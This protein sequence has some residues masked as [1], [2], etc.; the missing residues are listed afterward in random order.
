MAITVRLFRLTRVDGGFTAA[1]QLIR[2]GTV[3]VL[4]QRRNL[5]LARGRCR[6]ASRISISFVRYGAMN[7]CGATSPR[8]AMA[9]IRA[10]MI[11]IN[12]RPPFSQSF[13]N[14]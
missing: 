5:S 9:A 12:L 7:A 6:M 2:T 8:I 3:A 13:A 10:S 4:Q 11:K 14:N 1:M